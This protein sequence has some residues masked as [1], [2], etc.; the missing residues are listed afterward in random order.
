MKI[1]IIGGSK[2]IG[3]HLAKN[4]KE[5]HSVYIT[6]NNNQ[7]RDKNVF[8][9]SFHLDLNDISTFNSFINNLDE[10]ID[11][12]IFNAAI[13]QRSDFLKMKVNEYD[14]ILNI[15]LKSYVFFIQNLE[16]RKRIKKNIIFIFMSSVASEYYFPKTLH[17]MLSKVGINGLVKFLAQRYS[18]K[19]IY[20]NAISP[21][22]ILTD[23][24]RS[25]FESG[26]A[27][28]LINKTL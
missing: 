28:K 25:E 20:V 4:L 12:I 13:N 9:K 10:N 17:Y 5:N 7:L 18:N 21:G 26:A 14:N 15:N 3:L 23:Q 6:Y 27:E 19:N 16:K 24:T 22:L 8:K 11:V 2:G 1:L